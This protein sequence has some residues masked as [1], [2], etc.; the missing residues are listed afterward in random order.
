MRVA[1][2]FDIHGN[3]PA[4]EA[5]LAG[6]DAA[7]IDEIVVGGDIF[8]GP[9]PRQTLDRLLEIKLPTH[10]IHGNGEL[11]ILA[12][13]QAARTGV[14]KYW[15]T[16]SGNPLSEALQPGYRWNAE[17]VRDHEATLAGWPKTLTLAIDGLGKVLFCHGT[18]R[19][20]T[21][22][23]T[24]LTPEA[25]LKPLFDGIDAAVVVCGH[26][27][28]QFDRMIGA[29]RILNAGSVGEAFG[30]RGA[31]W[32]I[33]GP[34]VDFR[35][36]NYDVEAAAAAIRRTAYPQADEVARGIVSPSAESEMLEL[37]GKAEVK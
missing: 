36:T 16:T 30:E 21:E 28:M 17:Q 7:R 31:A 1:C 37:Y 35:H 34:G 15:G 5:V 29:K 26:T 4:L 18:P 32:L 19:S 22:I 6:V 10:F 9:M 24:R 11:A 27:H 33:L 20:E 8:P 23:F 13:I 25:V 12:Q 14:V 2:L 3:L